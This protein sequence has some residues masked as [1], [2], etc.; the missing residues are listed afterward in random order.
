VSKFVNEEEKFTFAAL[1]EQD[2]HA[3][4]QNSGRIL[5]YEDRKKEVVSQLD[6]GRD[7]GR[8]QSNEV[9]L[10]ALEVGETAM[11]LVEQ[12]GQGIYRRV[13]AAWDVRKD[14]FTGADGAVLYLR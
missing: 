7:I 10:L 5:V 4:Q 6:F 13:G 14:F 2:V 1:P 9:D 11:V 12:C 8:V 3:I